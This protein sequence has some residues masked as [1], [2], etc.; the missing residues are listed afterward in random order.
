MVWVTGFEPAMPCCQS[1]LNVLVQ[2]PIGLLGFSVAA[3][4][5]VRGF[6]VLAPLLTQ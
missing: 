6:E 5:S 2:V 1:R 3:T 4:C